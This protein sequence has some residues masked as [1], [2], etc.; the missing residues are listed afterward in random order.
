MINE[1]AHSGARPTTFGTATGATVTVKI[2]LRTVHR[3]RDP[4]R[5]R[6]IADWATS[7]VQTIAP[8]AASI[9]IPPAR[10]ERIGQRVARVRV[11]RLNL[12][13]A[14]LVRVQL[15][16]ALVRTSASLKR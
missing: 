6:V 2:V 4:H 16:E 8:V 5:H 15:P 1:S 3:S 9:V 14:W 10:I 13:I 7:G 11:T 12:V